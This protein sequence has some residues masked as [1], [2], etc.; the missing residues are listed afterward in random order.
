MKKFLKTFGWILLYLSIYFTLQVIYT[1]VAGIIVAVKLIVQNPGI[2][3]EEVQQKIPLLIAQQTTLAIIV[4]SILA[5]GLYYLIIKAR[6]ESF[7]EVCQFTKISWKNAALF[8]PVGIGMVFINGFLL[9]LIQKTEVMDDAF[10]KHIDLMEQLLSGSPILLYLAVAIA[11]PFIEEIIFRGL[12]LKELRKNLSIKWAI[13]IQAILFALYHMQLVQGIYTF[14]MGILLGLV[15]VWFK[16]IW[17]AIIIHLFNNLI[18]VILSRMTNV[19]I[20]NKLE[21]P[22]LIVSLGVLVSVVIYA[23]RNRELEVEEI[24]ENIEVPVNM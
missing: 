6:K 5:F 15:C 11:A 12:I 3:S 18:S 16:S 14:F 24:E 4:S 23:H 13:V 8:V 19:E 1:I 22:I 17:P 20:L 21:I 2:T 10:S 9:S 7:F